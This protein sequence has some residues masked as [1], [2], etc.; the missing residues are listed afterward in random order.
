LGRLGRDERP[1][2]ALPNALAI[3]HS[4]KSDYRKEIVE[5]DVEADFEEGPRGERDVACANANADRRDA[6][7]GRRKSRNLSQSSTGRMVWC[8]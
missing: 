1:G 6:A 7:V 4:A 3:Q 2:D 5:A 8:I